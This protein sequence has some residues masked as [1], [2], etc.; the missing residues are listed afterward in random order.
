MQVA[1]RECLRALL[2]LVLPIEAGAYSRAAR[3]D[4]GTRSKSPTTTETRKWLPVADLRGSMQMAG[5]RC[6]HALFGRSD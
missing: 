4:G 3:M 2:E 1:A 6:I 5:L